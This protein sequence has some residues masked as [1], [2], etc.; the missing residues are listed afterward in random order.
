MLKQLK[1]ENFTVFPKADL[2]FASGLN[3]F[4]GENGCGKSHLLKLLYAISSEN[5]SQGKKPNAQKP[6]KEILE[7]SYAEKLRNVFRVD[8]LDKLLYLTT[9][10]ILF[11]TDSVDSR[12]SN[13]LPQRGRFI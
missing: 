3:I 9:R 4:L 5:T 1:I 7:R 11:I 13:C 10:I 12:E 6:S 2:Q 8:A